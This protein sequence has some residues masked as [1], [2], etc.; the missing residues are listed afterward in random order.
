MGAGSQTAPTSSC[1]RPAPAAFLP[2]GCPWQGRCVWCRWHPARAEQGC[3]GGSS[4]WG[5]MCHALG[6]VSRSSEPPPCRP[7]SPARTQTGH[8][9]RARGTV[10][11]SSTA[12]PGVRGCETCP[13]PLEIP[14]SPHS[15]HRGVGVH[16]ACLAPALPHS[17]EARA[18]RGRGCGTAPQHPGG[19]CP[20]LGAPRGP[21]REVLGRVQGRRQEHGLST[22][23][24]Q[25]PNGVCRG[26]ASSPRVSAPPEAPLLAPRHQHA[27]AA[28]LAPFTAAPCW[29]QTPNVPLGSL[30]G[31]C[32][33]HNDRGQCGTWC[34]HKGSRCSQPSQLQPRGPQERS[35]DWGAP[36]PCK[37]LLR[38]SVPVQRL[39]QGGACRGD[40]GGG[41]RSSAP[42]RDAAAGA[43]LAK[44]RGAALC[45]SWSRPRA[46]GSIPGERGRG[47]AGA[48][49]ARP[50]SQPPVGRSRRRSWLLARGGP[51]P[52]AARAPGSGK[53]A[54][55]A[56][57]TK[58]RPLRA[59][60]PR[61]RAGFGW[62]LGAGLQP[63]LCW[64]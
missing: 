7:T 64:M 6:S 8:G 59:A 55:T 33:P 15:P 48:V 53:A 19:S 41:E 29:P 11:G 60:S 14:G 20:G 1:T 27:V 34:W 9:E 12:R 3:P 37:L 43:R 54:G 50:H 28:E 22:V 30:P 44:P 13:G 17:R 21:D 16:G 26:A 51:S 47:G 63:C 2:R 23:P 35:G 46:R 52:S 24:A 45:P 57:P 4:L 62:A 36:A 18:E 31:P 38:V 61:P 32:Q 10:A 40:R 25:D 56:S 49:G 39:R 42:P 5:G 58:T